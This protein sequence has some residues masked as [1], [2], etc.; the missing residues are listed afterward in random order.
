MPF[1][2]R[3]RSVVKVALAAL[4]SLVM[5]STLPSPARAGA[6]G[7]LRRTGLSAK[8]ADAF[9]TDLSSI[10]VRFDYWPGAERLRGVAKLR[11]TMRPGQERA[12]FHFN[13]QRH[14]GPAGEKRMLHGLTLDGRRLDPSDPRDLRIVRTAPGAEPTFEIQR[15]LSPG[16]AHRLRVAWAGRKPKA[17]DG[18]F[19]ATFDDTEGPKDE[20]ETLW[21]TV[22]SPEE[23]ARHRIRIRVHSDRPYTVLG[24]GH[25]APV[26]RGRVQSWL[27]DTGRPVASH[28]V[29]FAAVPAGDVRSRLLRVAGVAVRVVSNCQ[30][31]VIGQALRR[32]RNTIRH[33]VRDFGPFPMRRMQILLTP[34]DSGMEYY[35][36]TR[37]GI[38]ALRH[39]LAHMYFGA[40]TVNR[41]W[42]DTWI[43]EAAVVWWDEHGDF[44]PIGP[45]FRSTIASG[46][47]PA[48][49]GFN[50]RAYD[51]GARIF[52][53]VARALGGNRKMIA[54]LA[55]LH[56]NRAF[57]PFTTEQLIDDILAAQKKIDRADL[58]R[59]LLGG[60]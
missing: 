12:I 18:W 32:T 20:T 52:E 41:T 43:D 34:W 40:T 60:R 44:G 30:P 21:P 38:G 26:S 7:D 49:P 19:H 59:W 29:F 37:T 51:A 56:H 15:R 5:L 33:L 28:T 1:H 10:R 14:I 53:R 36:A 22:S 17:R 24:S 8:L 11:F 48:A 47:P 31:K 27:L 46:R 16:R 6:D 3:C 25:V 58:D 45:K 23:F 54:F 2:S 4:I 39:E 57:R 50:E 35:G 9:R 42:R 13:P 55:D